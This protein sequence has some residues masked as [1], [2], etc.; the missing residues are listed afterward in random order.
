MATMDWFWAIAE[1][2]MFAMRGS[3]IRR[4]LS[5]QTFVKDL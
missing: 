1:V 2:E 5:G 4:W 3:R